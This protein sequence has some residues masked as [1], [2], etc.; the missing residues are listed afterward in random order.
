MKHTAR[1]GPDRIMLR[2]R[3]AISDPERAVYFITD[4]SS[5]I[6]TR[7]RSQKN[8]YW[9]RRKFKFFYRVFLAA[10]LF[11]KVALYIKG[12]SLTWLYAILFVLPIIKLKTQ[13][14][15]LQQVNVKERSRCIY[16]PWKI[17]LT[18]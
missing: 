17:L 6:R 5:P 15:F 9:E 11:V 3:V 18:Y 2:A 12:M 1:L 13:M 7:P 4:A 14:D 8:F 10:I 16:L